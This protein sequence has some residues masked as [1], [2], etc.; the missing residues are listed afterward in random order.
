MINHYPLG[1]SE[2]QRRTKTDPL[3]KSGP[4]RVR[5]YRFFGGCEGPVDLGGADIARADVVWHSRYAKLG[6]SDD[7][8][9]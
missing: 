5:T 3:E 4:G 2:C 8:L 6:T 7:K 9:P 1:L